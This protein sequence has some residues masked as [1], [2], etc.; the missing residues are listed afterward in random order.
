MVYERKTNV[1]GPKIRQQLT[2]Y[3]GREKHDSCQKFIEDN[4]CEAR[5]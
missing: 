1:K 5:R 3:W 4:E 2:D